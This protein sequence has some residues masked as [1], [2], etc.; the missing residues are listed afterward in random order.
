[1]TYR[2]DVSSYLKDCSL[3]LGICWCS[4]QWLE[5]LVLFVTAVFRLIE[6]VVDAWYCT[7]LQMTHELDSLATIGVHVPTREEYHYD[8]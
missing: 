3:R 7:I 8:M 4:G 1:M 2:K 6:P 5:V